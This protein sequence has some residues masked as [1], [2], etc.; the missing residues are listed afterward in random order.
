MLHDCIVCSPHP[1][2][3]TSPNS[4]G[5]HRGQSARTAS[6]PAAAGPAPGA[7]L[8]ERWKRGRT[9]LPSSTWRPDENT[10][11]IYNHVT[12]NNINVCFLDSLRH[13]QHRVLHAIWKR[14]GLLRLICDLLQARLRR[15]NAARRL[16]NHQ[17]TQGHKHC[18]T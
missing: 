5:L 1:T 3:L 14:T 10:D 11:Y 6:T 2:A 15:G 4:V 17:R 12:I 9:P 7:K 18:I 16:M 13:H 8:Q